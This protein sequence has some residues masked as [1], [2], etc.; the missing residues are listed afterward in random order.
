M[1]SISP[2]ISTSVVIIVTGHPTSIL[3][4]FRFSLCI[5]YFA[6]HE[7]ANKFKGFFSYLVRRSWTAL[8]LQEWRVRMQQEKPSLARGTK[9]LEGNLERQGQ[10]R[11]PHP[12]FNLPRLM[13]MQQQKSGAEAP[14]GLW[15]MNLYSDVIALIPFLRSPPHLRSISIRLSV[16][17]CSTCSN[18]LRSTPQRLSS[19]LRGSKLSLHLT[20]QK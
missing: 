7:G 19:A 11:M 5:D 15:Q 9:T 8:K 10:G 12:L 18:C 6:V 16:P 4:C 1:F 20:V 3:G 17:L 2:S 14:H 13:W